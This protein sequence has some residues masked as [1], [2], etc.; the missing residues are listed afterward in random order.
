MFGVAH[1][2]LMWR[3]KCKVLRNRT[4]NE[5]PRSVRLSMASRNPVLEVSR[6]L[7]DLKAATHSQHKDLEQRLPLLD[8]N[9][10]HATCRHFVQ[11]LFGFHEP[12]EAQLLSIPGWDALGVDDTLRHKTPRLAA[13]TRPSISSASGSFR[14]RRRE[15]RDSLCRR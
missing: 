2:S 14:S 7:K 11:R 12:L 1:N 5:G 13:P 9:L 3:M 8:T 10:S 6:M 4:A 15:T